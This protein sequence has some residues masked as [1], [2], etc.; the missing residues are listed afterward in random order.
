[1]LSKFEMPA[2]THLLELYSSKGGNFDPA[3]QDVQ[4]AVPNVVAALADAPAL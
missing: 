2:R 3:L 4:A 1:M